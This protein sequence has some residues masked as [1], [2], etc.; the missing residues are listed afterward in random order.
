VISPLL[1]NIYLHE[2][3]D[4]WFAKDVKPRLKG[5]AFMI[6]FADDAVLCFE[7]EEDARRVM[8]VLPK[9]LARF[10]LRLHPDKTRL[11]RFK[12]PPA[13]P[14]GP[15]SGKKPGTFDM[16]GFTH[17]WGRSRRGY[18]VVM[19]RTAP[20]RMSRALRKI[21]RWCRWA[22]H[23]PVKKQHSIL[24]SKLRGHYNYYG[25]T[26]NGKAIASF[27]YFVKRIW[28]KWLDRRSQRARMKWKR[29][30]RLLQRYPLP[31]PVVVHSIYKR[32]A[33]P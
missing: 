10:G 11:V 28:R 22:R 6:R 30:N 1:S 5:G 33:N 21:T 3:L 8:S 27:F 14:R 26:G 19:R 32:S 31:P 16:L 9:R 24:V 2:V 29:F 12:R 13:G 25:I 7:R 23:M 4:Q 17:Y 18:W 20:E 15:W